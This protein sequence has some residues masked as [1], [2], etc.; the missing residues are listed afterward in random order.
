M[1]AFYAVCLAFFAS[2]A[3]AADWNPTYCN[4]TNNCPEDLP[5]CSQY[6]MCG[7]G[8][9][10]LGG[11]DI[12]RSFNMSACM[13][14]PRMKSFEESFEDIDHIEKQNEYLGNFTEADWVYTG[15]IANHDDALL[16]QMP[17]QST[18]SVVSS[19]KYLWYGKVG[20]TVKSSRG[21]GVVTAFITFSDVQ[22][23]IDYEFLGYDLEKVESNYYYQGVLNY[24]NQKMHDLSDT[25]QNWHYYEIDWKED[26]LTWSI[27]GNVV[28]TLKKSDTYN[29]TSDTYMYP[30]TPSR[31]QFSLWPGGGAGN[32]A[33]TI[34]WAG[35]KID[36]DSE[37]IKKTGYYY[38]YVKN[39]SVETYDLPDFAKKNASNKT[40]DYH[41]FLYSST[42]ANEKDVFLTKKKT[43]LGSGDATGF[44]P[45]NEEK[46]ETTTSGSKTITKTLSRSKSGTVDV[47]TGNGNGGAGGNRGGS[48]STSSAEYTGGFV[49][50]SHATGS[51]SSSSGGSGSGNSSGAPTYTVER[52]LALAAGVVGVVFTF[53]V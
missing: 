28:R 43:W 46:V 2:F 27:D 36:W 51:S 20:A 9:Y 15:H 42:K 4:A 5:C 30:Q 25:F 12:R 50:N 41:A 24:T 17:N 37:D 35:G 31:V 49:Q 8:S 53:A 16:L 10:C 14:M 6:G 40:D 29:S 45:D 22:D 11:C 19:T 21:N 1:R 44:D 32:A 13:P 48:T 3:A 34:E 23:E 39:V 33:G 52:F 47:P 38:A 7:T 18:G 26:I